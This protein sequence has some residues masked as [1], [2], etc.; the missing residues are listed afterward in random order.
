L[1]SLYCYARF[2]SYIAAGTKIPF[3]EHCACAACSNPDVLHYG[4]MLRDSDHSLFEKDIVRE[5]SDLS[6]TETV[7][8]LSTTAVSDGCAV[9]LAIWSFRQK[10]ALH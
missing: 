10:C 9:L 5:I 8:I 1:I 7:E 3:L 2:I 6:C 4:D